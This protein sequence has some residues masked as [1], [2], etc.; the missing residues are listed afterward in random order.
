MRDATAPER[1]WIAAR[2]SDPA[3]YASRNLRHVPLGFWRQVVHHC[4]MIRAQNHALPLSVDGR[5]ARDPADRQAAVFG[6]NEALKTLNLQEWSW[7]VLDWLRL[8]D[9][10][11]QY[12]PAHDDPMLATAR[13]FASIVRRRTN[14]K[15]IVAD[16]IKDIELEPFMHW[17]AQWVSI[18]GDAVGPA[19]KPL[20]EP[21]VPFWQYLQNQPSGAHELRTQRLPP[22]HVDSQALRNWLVAGYLRFVL[23]RRKP[24]E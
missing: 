4:R 12:L 5:P 6:I 11:E 16:I 18:D 19:W 13:V 8:Y 9:G 15:V 7:T 17:H 21:P 23:P 20:A 1:A 24:A 2:Y 14:T 22:M 3:R 10:L